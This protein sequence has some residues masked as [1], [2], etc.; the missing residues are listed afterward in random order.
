MTEQ[1]KISVRR[2][3]AE[4][5]AANV[6]ALADVLIDCVEG[7]ASVSFTLP[8]VRENALAPCRQ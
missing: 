2:I 4:E 8:L 7:G 1:I 3:A 6:E 5:A